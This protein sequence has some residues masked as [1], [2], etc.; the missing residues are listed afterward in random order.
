MPSGASRACDVA[1]VG[2]GAAGLAA[3]ER[4]ARAG[5][6]TVIFDEQAVPGGSLLAD[7]A[8][9]PAAA[10]VA[11]DAART[12][13]AELVVD[14]VAIG[15]FPD[16]GGM[17]AVATPDRLVRVRARATI[18][19]TGGYPQNLRFEDNDRPGVIAARAAARL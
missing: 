16:D 1:I 8:H 12:A 14:E 13:G 15:A 2:G 4:C 5:L 11:A 6:A 3:A 7:P 9:G 18:H 17:I 10:A 19:A